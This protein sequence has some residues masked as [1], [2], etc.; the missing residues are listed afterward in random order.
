MKTILHKYQ[1]G[2]FTFTLHS[3]GT[4]IRE[5]DSSIENPKIVHP[6]SIDIKLTDYCD[7]G[8]KFCHESSTVE[9]KHADLSDLMEKLGEL[10]RGVELACGG[11]NPLSHPNIVPFLTALKCLGFIPN[12]TVNQGHLLTYYDLIVELIERK[13]IY[14][15]G[16]SLINNNYKTI[17]LLME[18]TNNIVF[19]II[20]GVSNISIL[21]K[22][23]TEFGDD[24]KVLILGYKNFGF[25]VNYNS[26][27]V[28]SN[29]HEWKNGIRKYFNK[30][31]ISFDNLAL[32]QLD[33]KSILTEEAWD[34]FY[35][36]DDFVY[37][38]YIDAVKKEF[39]PTSRSNDRV[40]FSD[41]SLLD[42]F[43]K[44]K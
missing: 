41:S 36:G 27:I 6:S 33:V 10:P 19:H 37:T 26:P 22:L 21:D 28:Q 23:H 40:S 44:N 20:A 5:V 1:N 31:T 13:L 39:A 17:K 3:D 42:Y 18:K 43:T 8:C 11:G 24:I 34:K 9:G 2:D 35:M 14:G 12:L 30:F 32:E 15:L 4:L 7:M 16:I 38:M 25:G 29:I